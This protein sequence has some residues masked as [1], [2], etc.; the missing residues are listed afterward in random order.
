MANEKIF[1]TLYFWAETRCFFMKLWELDH[2]SLFF[3]RRYRDL[4]IGEYIFWYGGYCRSWIMFFEIWHIFCLIKQ[5]GKILRQNCFGVY[6]DNKK[7]WGCDTRSIYC[8]INPCKCPYSLPNKDDI[9]FLKQMSL[10]EVV[11]EIRIESVFSY[12]S[13]FIKMLRLKI[14]SNSIRLCL[15][16]VSCLDMWDIPNTCKHKKEVIEI[17]LTILWKSSR[18]SNKNNS[19]GVLLNT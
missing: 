12:I 4:K 19:V 8:F 5:E 6:P 18:M 1:F 17:T 7:C 10:L 15:E 14:Y 13:V 9:I 2:Y 11:T 3:Y 16:K